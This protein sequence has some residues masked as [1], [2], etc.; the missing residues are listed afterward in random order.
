MVWFVRISWKVWVC[1]LVYTICMYTL[2]WPPFPGIVENEGFIWISYYTCKN[3]GGDYG[4]E[5]CQH[6]LYTRITPLNIM[7]DRTWIVCCFKHTSIYGGLRGGLLSRVYIYRYW[8]HIILF[9]SASI[10]C[11][12]R[13]W[14]KFHQEHRWTF[15]WRNKKLGRL[16]AQDTC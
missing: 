13:K 9:P 3:R 4:W 7:D 5:G 10:T 14:R 12:A 8:L 6:N 11:S 2:G 15:P 1:V 16:Y